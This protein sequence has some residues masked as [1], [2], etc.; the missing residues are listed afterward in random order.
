MTKYV[1][2]TGGVVSGLGKGITAAS[3]G[4]LLKMRGVKVTARKLD[5]YMNIDPGYLNP[6]EHGEVF[7]TD[8]GA[9]TDLDLGHYERFIDENLSNLSSISA[10]EVY[11]RV[12]SRERS[13]GYNGKT[14]QIIPHITDE[15]K[16]FVYEGA[17]KSGATVNITE[18]GGTA[19]DIECQPFLEAARQIVLEKGRANCLFIHV[20]LVPF[21][22]G[23]DELKT[24]PTQHSVKLLQSYGIT[25][26]IIVTRCD[27]PI[28]E[29]YKKKIALFC[30]VKQDCVIENQTLDVLYEAPIAMNK[31]GLDRVVCRELGL[32]TPEPD[33]SMWAAMLERIK[34]RSKT[35]R[36][37]IVGKY[38]KLHDAYLSII[39]SLSHGGYECGTKIKI[40]WID[41]EKLG[42]GDV[43]AQNTLK[44]CN[45]I[46][47]PEGFGE[48]GM[49]GKIVACNYARVNNIPFL[50]I[51]M[52]MQAAIIEFARNAANIKDADS[53]EFAPDCKNR[54]IEQGA[55]NA[56]TGSNM[57]VGSY[58]C[59]IVKGTRLEKIYGTNKVAERHR[60]R[61]E[62]NLA[63]K[64]KLEASGLKI[65][66]T[67][68]DGK[69]VEA[70]E[71]PSNGFFVGVVFQPQF[72]SRPN[73]AH[74]LFREFVKATSDE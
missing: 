20:T 48:R 49:N 61:Y 46:L 16:N 33:L 7:V 42:A 1:F 9:E 35:T 69:L 68:P 74:P 22:S 56:K 4:R 23:S 45:G 51:G 10:G 55:V 50:G 43:A 67:S 64:S 32:V 38:V 31:N 39:E 54:V 14:V 24:K 28:S 72:K 17:K 34:S 13:G 27:R 36:I 2:V 26:D 63:F 44:N 5:P 70:V 59:N 3:L 65:S 11:W 21:L 41:S 30:N 29:S 71:I 12:L 8:D 53:Y 40:E 47:V 6:I 58:P 52:G 66:G 62:F 19:G 57:R 73:R 15:I 60:H 37:A 25:P 18:I